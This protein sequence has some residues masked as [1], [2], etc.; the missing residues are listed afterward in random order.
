VAGAFDKTSMAMDL[1][2][3]NVE[4]SE[5]ITATHVEGSARSISAGGFLGG[6]VGSTPLG[7]G[8]SGYA[9]TPMEKSIR[10]CIYEAVKFVVEDT[11]KEYYK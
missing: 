11:P 4:T 7:G 2:L 10:A 3:V 1:R 9:K 5:V 6:L 8:L